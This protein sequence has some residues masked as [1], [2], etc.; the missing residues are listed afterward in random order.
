MKLTALLLCVI[1]VASA[2]AQKDFSIKGRFQM[3]KP[4]DWIHLEYKNGETYVHD[5]IQPHNG[6]FSYKGKLAEPGL[7]QIRLAYRKAESESEAKAESDFLFLEPGKTRLKIK[8]T[9]TALTVKGSKI[10]K[11][12]QVLIDGQNR[13]AMKSAGYLKATN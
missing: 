9:I 4:V 11:E 8:D 6:N 2:Q 3:Q 10:H 7:V 1:A 12:Y 5:S 13:I